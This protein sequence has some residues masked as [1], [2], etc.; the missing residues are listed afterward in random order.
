MKIVKITLNT[1]LIFFSLCVSIYLCEILI[2]YLYEKH[3]NYPDL[4][5]I[6]KYINL[7]KKN[8]HIRDMKS[9]LIDNNQQYYSI[10]GDKLQKKEA[11]IF[12][13]DSWAEITDMKS[14][15]LK[16]LMLKKA[17][18]FINGGTSSY[19]PS[20]M[21][22]QL[23]DIVEETGYKINLLITYIDQ[24]D[25]MDEVCDYSN[26]RIEE[27][28]K[29]ISVIKASGYLHQRY[30][31]YYQ[32]E[33]FN[34]GIP[35]LLF[36]IENHLYQYIHKK[37]IHK[38]PS[39]CKWD[40]I[41]KFMRGETKKDEEK[42]FYNSLRTYL[43][44][45]LSYTNNIILITHKHRKHYEGDYI[46][47]IYDVLSKGVD[48]LNLNEQVKVIDISPEKI[49]NLNEIFPSHEIDPASH[50]FINYYNNY[51]SKKIFEL[52]D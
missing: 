31:P 20:L 35:K 43:N 6:K 30:S 33:K 19:S 37:M 17:N 11:I 50:P 41:S 18:I 10:H 47:D 52:V 27:D 40:D 4:N 39:Y 21:E 16:N 48:E 34:S 25:F 38:S 51:F 44:T 5:Q 7:G 28:G 2:G 46:N 49:E 23:K 1:I 45:A 12:Q 42:I 9:Y 29:L 24:T 36:F 22:I 8:H 13:G 3:R 32:Y 26:K 15:V 14:D